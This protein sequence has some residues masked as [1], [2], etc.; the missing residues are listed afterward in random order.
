MHGDLTGW[1]GVGTVVAGLA[2]LVGAHGPTGVLLLGSDGDKASIAWELTLAVL[3]HQNGVSGVA[4]VGFVV[5][6]MVVAV[7]S[8]NGRN[9]GDERGLRGEL[10]VG[11]KERMEGLI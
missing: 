8:L 2:R 4:R 3:L 1:A 9:E 10:H 11:L 5:T 7:T 6:G